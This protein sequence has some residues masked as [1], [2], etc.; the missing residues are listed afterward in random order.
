MFRLATGTA[1]S[2]WRLQQANL[3]AAT[4]SVELMADTYARLWGLPA[5]EEVLPADRRFADA[6]WQENVAFDVLKQT[7]LITTQW[8]V[9]VADGL[10]EVHPA[11]HQRA[12]FWAR[13]AAD[14]LSPTNIA[15]TNPVV[16][17]EIVRTGGMNLV[18]GMQNLLSDLE[19]G[20]ISQVQEG[21]FEVGK[22]LAMTPGK[23]VFRSPLIELIQYTP[24]TKKVRAVPILV[25]PPWINKYYV[26]DMRP[27]NS[28]FKYLVDAG[29]TVFAISWKNPDESILDLE[30]ADYMLRGPVTAMQVVKSITGS[31]Q[32]NMVGYCLGGIMVQFTLAYLAAAGEEALAEFDLPAVSAATCFTTHQDFSNVGDIAAFLSEPEV[33]FLEWLMKVSGGY[34][35][36]R[37]MASTFNMLR[38]NDLLWHYVIENYLMGR[39]PPAFD[40][41]YWNGDGTRVPGR[42]HSFLLREFFLKNKLKEPGGI[43]VNGVGIDVGKVNV[44]TY[45]VAASGDHIVPWQGAFTMRQLQGGPVRFILTGGGHIAG[46]I[47]PPGKKGRSYWTNDDK[48]TDAEAWLAGATSHEGSWWSDWVPWLKKRSGNLIAPPPAGNDAYPSL[49]DA[50]GSYVLE[51]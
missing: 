8:M 51:K 41:L 42:V 17:Q 1:A 49:L 15:L 50:P 35:D 27:E 43:Q 25:V 46:I 13:Q 5:G 24:A 37:N 45:C 19:K 39:E 30:W 4:R 6:A 2:L 29:F 33:K 32:V 9:E 44:P 23:V 11:V 34:L 3:T 7:Y 26:M 36:G 40:L 12:V 28:L 48:T 16:L 21:A 18:H 31:E 20:R 22:N 14:A 47:N 10:E 38:S